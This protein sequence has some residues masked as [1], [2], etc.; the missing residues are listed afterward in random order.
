MAVMATMVNA[1]TTA[2]KATME[3]M[4]LIQ[5]T[6]A[7]IRAATVIRYVVPYGMTRRIW[8]TTRRAFNGM[9]CTCT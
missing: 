5:A 3:G 7:I 6:A 1:V 4:G 9:D 8:I 2:I